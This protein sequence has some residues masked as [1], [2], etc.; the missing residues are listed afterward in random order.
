[1]MIALRDPAVFPLALLVTH[2]NGNPPTRVETGLVARFHYGD[3]I[4]MVAP[5]DLT[6]LIATLTAAVGRERTEEET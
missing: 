5:D 4:V 3:V 1:M 2:A 6:G